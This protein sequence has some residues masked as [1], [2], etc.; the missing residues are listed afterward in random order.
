MPHLSTAKLLSCQKNRLS[1]QK[2]ERIN[3]QKQSN[4]LDY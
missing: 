1:C 3:D 2:N 4:K